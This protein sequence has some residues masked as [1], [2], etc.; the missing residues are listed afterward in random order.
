MFIDSK[1]SRPREFDVVALPPL[2]V[3]F[4]FFFM[5][6]AFSCGVWLWWCLGRALLKCGQTEKHLGSAQKEF[7][8]TAVS[9]FVHPMK[10]FLEEEMKTLAVSLQCF[11]NVDH[12][13]VMAAFWGK[14]GV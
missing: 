3:A 5:F 1:N 9:R 10:K 6:F 2:C 7:V 12:G 8:S 4:S 13:R 11:R 14:F